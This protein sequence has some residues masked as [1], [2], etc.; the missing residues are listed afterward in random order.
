MPAKS[1]D[2]PTPSPRAEL[3]V[4]LAALDPADVGPV[5]LCT[6]GKLLLRPALTGPEL[7]HSLPE[8]PTHAVHD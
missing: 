7:P 8:R 2:R 3:Q 5:Q 4:V 1:S 6:F